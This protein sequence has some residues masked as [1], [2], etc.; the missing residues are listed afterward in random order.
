MMVGMVAATAVATAAAAVA[1]LLRS[2]PPHEQIAPGSGRAPE[3]RTKG[4]NLRRRPQVCDRSRN[5][6]PQ[7]LPSR[8]FQTPVF[9]K[10]HRHSGNKMRWKM[11]LRR[12]AKLETPEGISYDPAD[13]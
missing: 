4:S 1:A 3:C 12:E 6:V 10:P 7:Y 2:Q 9:N 13:V 5:A 11:H 8:E